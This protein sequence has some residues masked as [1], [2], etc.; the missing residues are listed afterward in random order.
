MLK[1]LRAQGG[2]DERPRGHCTISTGKRP[3]P[4]AS[5]VLMPPDQ[6]VLRRLYAE[7]HRTATSAAAEERSD[8]APT[9]RTSRGGTRQQTVFDVKADEIPTAG[10]GR[11]WYTSGLYPLIISLARSQGRRAWSSSSHCFVLPRDDFRRGKSR[12]AAGTLVA[13]QDKNVDVSRLGGFPTTS[14]KRSGPSSRSETS[15]SD[16]DISKRRRRRPNLRGWTTPDDRLYPQIV[17]FGRR[18]RVKR[19]R[20]GT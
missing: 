5:I 17:V 3:P 12:H 2:V 8:D 14:D 13:L 1:V 9:R 4:F 11:S 18:A 19:T 20:G 7:K 15:N 6:T 10:V 16:E